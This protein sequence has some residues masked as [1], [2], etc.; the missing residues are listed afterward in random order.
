MSNSLEAIRNF[1]QLTPEIGT[2]GQPRRDQFEQIAAAGY[3]TVINLAMPDHTDAIADEGSLVTALGMT[4]CHL[5]V[6]FDRPRVDHLQRFLALL[7]AFRGPRLFIHCIMN[8]RVS[9]F[10][11]HYLTCFEGYSAAQARSPIFDIW[12]PEPQW[13]AILELDYDSLNPVAS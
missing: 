13:R 10:M 9:A 3:I 6:P 8:Y 12:E 2:A 4:Y 1:V 7:Q 5:P 11:F